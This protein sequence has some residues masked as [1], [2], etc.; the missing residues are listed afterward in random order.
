M[1]V[2]A[3]LAVLV[4]IGFMGSALFSGA[5]TG[6]Y[7]FNRTRHRIALA[8]G[9]R[10][11]HH[12]QLL[13]G[14][15]TAFVVVCLIGTNLAN[16]L[17]SQATTYAFQDLSFRAPELIAT[18]VIAPVLFVIGELAP[19]E[20]FRRHPGRLLYSSA[21]LLR[22]AKFLFQPIAFLMKLITAGMRLF[23]LPGEGDRRLAAEERVRQAIAA[24]A[25]AGTLTA[26]QT[27]LARNIFSLSARRVLHAMLP[28]DR[29]DRLEASMPIE[30]A[31]AYVRS[32]GRARY[33][34]YSNDEAKV[35]GLIS[36]Y[37][38]LFEERPGMTIRN[39]IQPTLD[40]APTERVA[41]ALVR[42]RRA[43]V[44]M[45][46]VSDRGRALGII[47]LKDLV[48]EITG[49]LRDL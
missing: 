48:E 5:E 13:T 44:N 21:P 16:T 3:V 29:V 22:V 40:V 45:A 14:D 4:L 28:L 2:F 25:E 49:E 9:S 10:Q 46:I 39:Y 18:L 23:G 42:M 17:V 11:A 36:M 19:K 30:E 43:R 31:R 24:G 15:L 26:Y 1:S 37:D 32:H 41:E 38:L 12:V 47:T 27:T 8:E 34:V 6:A 33:P 7:Q 20:Y 35:V